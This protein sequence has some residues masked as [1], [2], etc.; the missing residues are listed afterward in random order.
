MTQNKL[1]LLS[2]LCCCLK[3]ASQKK[4]ELMAAERV[5]NIVNCISH[6]DY[7]KLADI[8]LLESSWYC[9]DKTHKESI[10]YFCRNWLEE[11][12]EYWEEYYEKKFT[13]DDFDENFL[14]F[15]EPDN[16]NNFIFAVYQ[17]T[18]YGEQL[19]F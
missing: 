3:N 12:L 7:D 11:Q 4:F 2:E 1:K 19:D 10:Y 15:L 16:I 8:T 18:S 17:P 9:E 6:K 13:V 5:K 14:D